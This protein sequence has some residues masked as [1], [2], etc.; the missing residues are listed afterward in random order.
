MSNREGRR[1]HVKRQAN[2]AE[3]ELQLRP[4]FNI[5][6]FNLNCTDCSQGVRTGIH[7]TV[8]KQRVQECLVMEN[9]V[10]KH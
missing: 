7:L 1:L 3:I 5:Y 9:V 8:R 10:D 4:V 6:I 2:K